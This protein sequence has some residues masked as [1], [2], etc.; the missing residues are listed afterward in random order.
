MSIDIGSF[1]TR[2]PGVVGGRP[3]IDGTRVT[4]QSIAICYK[5]GM[6]PE[7]IVFQYGYLSAAQVYAALAYYHAHQDEIEAAIKAEE[8]LY[9]QMARADRETKRAAA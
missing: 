9:D 3:R 7:E 4:V 2:T 8:E 5:R 6:M 1:I